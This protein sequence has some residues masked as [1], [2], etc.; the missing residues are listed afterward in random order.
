MSC[1][2]ILFEVLKNLIKM[3]P[4]KYKYDKIKSRMRGE[5]KNE[6]IA[7]WNK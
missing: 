6:K 3:Q 1:K 5:K 7:K 2:W 4:I